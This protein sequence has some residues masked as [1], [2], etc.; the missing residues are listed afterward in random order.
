MRTLKQLA[1]DTILKNDLSI[2]KL[3]AALKNPLNVQLAFYRDN[4]DSLSREQFIEEVVKSHH[5]ELMLSMDIPADTGMA[6]CAKYGFEIG[7]QYYEDLPGVK[8]YDNCLANAAHSGDVNIFTHCVRKGATDFKR[9]LGIACIN[10]HDMILDNIDFA[11]FVNEDL[12][13]SFVNLG[14][15][16]DW[17]F[18][19]R[20]C[21]RLMSARGIDYSEDGIEYDL[22]RLSISDQIFQA[23][24]EYNRENFILQLSRSLRM[25]RVNE[26][27]LSAIESHDNINL[28]AEFITRSSYDELADYLQQAAIYLRENTLK[29]L[30]FQYIPYQ[31][32][33]IIEQAVEM[34]DFD[35]LERFIPEKH[36]VVF[37]EAK[38]DDDM[39][40]IN[41]FIKV[42]Y[43]VDLFNEKFQNGDFESL[44]DVFLECH[45]V[46]IRENIT[47]RR[48]D[49]FII[50]A[51]DI[52]NDD[53]SIHAE[54]WGD[55]F[56]QYVNQLIE[57][58]EY[59]KLQEIFLDIVLDE[60]NHAIENDNVEY[61]IDY[62]AENL[63]SV[64]MFDSLKNGDIVIYQTDEWL[65]IIT[66]ILSAYEYI[67]DDDIVDRDGRRK[68]LKILMKSSSID[69]REIVPYI[70]YGGF[71]YILEDFIER[72]DI[73]YNDEL[74]YIKPR[75]D[76][77]Q[78][79]VDRC[80]R[81]LKMHGK[82]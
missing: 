56:P 49:N 1:F 18:F 58:E 12:E 31:V 77:E 44:K 37:E 73:D 63:A 34:K 28:T 10:G 2:D 39:D 9:A 16:G 30:C 40:R 57:S 51:D 45:K 79:N 32:F 26:Y 41:K 29:K 65:N 48:F 21:E 19:L 15:R 53:I 36:A 55:T 75:N 11:Q 13:E 76:N 27:C 71:D 33:S 17:E 8:D 66:N 81:L 74:R 67:S 43:Y 25:E 72:Y 60:M 24:A 70:L 47:K 78:R 61:F 6:L 4:K 59:L 68:I 20:F 38:A 82:I 50:W 80:V 3:P 14:I 7:F 62:A 23:A 42:N 22:N 5:M 52:V 46:N 69:P 64:T 35:S 54:R